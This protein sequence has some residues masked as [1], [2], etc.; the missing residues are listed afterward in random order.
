MSENIAIALISGIVSLIGTF[1]SILLT[2]RLDRQDRA[3]GSSARDFDGPLASRATSPWWTLFLLVAGTAIGYVSNLT[4]GIHA[5]GES[6][7]PYKI[8]FWAIP[9][10]ALVT[11][12]L[13]V[14]APQRNFAV[15]ALD[16][17]ALWAAFA[18]G[19]CLV[20][21]HIFTDALTTAATMSVVS[22]VVG[23]LAFAVI[24]KR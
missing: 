19:V 13:R 15:Y 6:S 10:L 20:M 1:G 8:L 23:G 5:I 4:V 18:T 3:G 22:I 16:M 9:A 7:D 14:R 11:L 24:P 2:R 21:H 12:V 17:V